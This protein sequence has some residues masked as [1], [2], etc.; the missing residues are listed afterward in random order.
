M[1]LSDNALG[2]GRC[3]D[4]RSVAIPTAVSIIITALE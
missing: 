3:T 4:L 1:S 2:K